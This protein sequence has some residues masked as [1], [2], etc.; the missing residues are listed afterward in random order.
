M[1]N[2]LL[3]NIFYSI[4]DIKFKIIFSSILIKFFVVGLVKSLSILR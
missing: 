4:L 3:T 1:P 2:I